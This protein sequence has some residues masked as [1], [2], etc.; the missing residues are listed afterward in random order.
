MDVSICITTY[1]HEKYIV[2]CLESIFAQEF[3]GEYEIIIGNDNSSDA[4]ENVIRQISETHIKGETIRYFKNNPNLGYVKNTLFTFSQARG[5]YIAVL[6]G[7]D[8]WTDSLKLQKQFDLLEN[9]SLLSAAGS[10]SR[11]IYEDVDKESHSYSDLPARILKK[12]GLTDLSI[13]Q[14]STFFFRKE[15]LQDDFPT[16]I[17]SA[18]RGLYLLAGCFG[19][20][21]YMSEE[22][23]AYRQFQGS[24]S[25][26]VPYEVMKKDF[27]IVPFI[28]KH[29]SEYRTSKLMAYFYYTLMAYPKTVSRTNFYR[30]AAG[31]AFYN[32][33]SKFTLRPFKLYNV[34]KWTRHTM[35]QK[36]DIK[37]QNNGFI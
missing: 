13:F 28:K 1:N 14:T 32:I 29:N 23:A 35:M 31:Y 36:Y 19:D 30:A 20:V 9:N 2:K 12:E 21:Q 5:K 3:S 27:A 26:N 37:K 34:L 18:D 17:I 16:D 7:D 22:T 4:T 6:D 10:N 8:Y 11:V 15:I 24:I 33:L 25:K